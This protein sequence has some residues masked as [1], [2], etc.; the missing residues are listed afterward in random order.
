MRPPRTL[1]PCAASASR[2]AVASVLPCV[3]ALAPAPACAAEDATGPLPPRL[4]DR[5]FD[6]FLDDREV[7]GHRYHFEGDP[8]DFRLESRAEFAVKIA[9]VTVFSY[10]HEADEHWVDGCLVTLASETE[11][12]REFTVDA[13][14]TSDGFSVDTGD[15]GQTYAWACPWSFAYWNPA[16]RERARL[17]NP[18]D[19]KVFDLSF[20]ALEPAPLTIGE[21]SVRT[22]RWAMTGEKLDVTLYYDEQDRWLGL[23]SVVEGGRV[24]RYRPDPSDPFYPR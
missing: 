20:E 12:R 16:L 9:F 18:Q 13:R 17:V 11:A 4:E 7:G 1:R 10:D 2:F 15:G 23:D 22:R 19:G 5:V 6:V 24:L 3:L 8:S 14:R 21:R